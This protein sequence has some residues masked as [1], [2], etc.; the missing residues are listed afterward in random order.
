MRIRVLPQPT[1]RSIDGIRLD[2][3]QVGRVYELGQTLGPLFVAEG[4]AVPQ[5]VSSRVGYDERDPFTPLRYRNADDPWNL[6]REHYPPYLDDDRAVA[7][8]FE[9]CRRRRL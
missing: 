2:Q 6:V 4:W 5:D 9:R 8:D 1:T 3:F 7:A